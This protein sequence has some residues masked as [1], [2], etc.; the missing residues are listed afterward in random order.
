MTPQQAHLQAAAIG[1]D[2]LSRHHRT[3][4]GSSLAYIAGAVSADLLPRKTQL[5]RLHTNTM[6]ADCYKIG[7]LAASY[8][9]R[10]KHNRSAEV[11]ITK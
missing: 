1:Y 6:E 3:N 5:S 7:S 10:E 2:A 4:I 8:K 9:Q 11:C